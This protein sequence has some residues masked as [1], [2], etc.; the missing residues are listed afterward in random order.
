MTFFIGQNDEEVSRTTLFSTKQIIAAAV[1][2][3]AFDSTEGICVFSGEDPFRGKKGSWK[4]GIITT[5]GLS[6]KSENL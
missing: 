4:L 1:S 5:S 6:S 3:A 2:G